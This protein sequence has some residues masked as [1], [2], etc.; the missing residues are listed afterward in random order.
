[1]IGLLAYRPLL[2]P[3]NVHDIWW[4]FLVPMALGISIVY[5][6]VRVQTMDRYRQQVA[7]MT[8]QII[9]GMIALAVVSYLFVAVYVR[10]VAD[11]IG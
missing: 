4:M 9:L 3:L 5:K 11:R 10:F 7:I 1:M 8:V 2:D 6:A